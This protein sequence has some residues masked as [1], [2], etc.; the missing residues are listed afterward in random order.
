MAS[1]VVYQNKMATLVEEHEVTSL[2]TS[3]ET[4]KTSGCRIKWIQL[5]NS[6]MA[7]VTYFKAYNK[8]TAPVHATDDPD[9]VWQ[10]EAGKVRTIQLAPGEAETG[11]ANGELFDTGLHLCAS[12]SKDTAGSNP[13]SQFDCTLGVTSV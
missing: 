6:R 10:V 5:D 3:P 12:N 8:A 1:R 4:L 11:A 7:A 2:T 9:M 13:A